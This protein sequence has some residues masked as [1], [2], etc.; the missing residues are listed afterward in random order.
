MSSLAFVFVCFIFEAASH[1]VALTVLEGAKSYQSPGLHRARGGGQQGGWGI[2]LPSQIG[3]AIC[4]WGPR[5][6]HAIPG[7]LGRQSDAPRGAGPSSRSASQ[8]SQPP[9]GYVQH[10][11]SVKTSLHFPL[12]L[13][14]FFLSGLY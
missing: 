12:T 7:A 9:A 4:T 8:L 6:S 1:Y 2:N 10:P 11:A 14:C 3:E 5:V 13:L